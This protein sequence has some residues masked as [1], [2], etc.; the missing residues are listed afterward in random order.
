MLTKVFLLRVLLSFLVGGLYIALTIR[1]SE[2]FGSKIGGLLIA[3]PSIVLV[4]LVFIAITESQGALVLATTNMPANISASTIFLVVFVMTYRFGWL[5]AYF[6]ALAAWFALTLPLIYLGFHGMRW[7]IVMA[8]VLFTISL[9]FFHRRPDTKLPI[10]PLSQ[11]AFLFRIIFSGSF[12][13]IAVLLA[14]VL[15]PHWGGLFASFPAAFSSTILLLAPKYG[16][17]FIASLSRSMVNGALANAVFVI[18]IYWLVPL[19]G[20]VVGMASAYA[21]CLV[22]ALFSYKY[23]M[24]RV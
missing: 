22:F 16:I 7:P 12:V 9:A 1:I 23:I 19:L 8:A 5:M 11:E 21:L 10:A 13:A 2:R 6:S 3:L 17:E 14:R 18:G 24:S 4:G 20:V 15:G